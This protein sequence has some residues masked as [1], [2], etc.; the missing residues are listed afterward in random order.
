MKR[1]I[2]G[3]IMITLM[4]ATIIPL[5]AATD[6]QTTAVGKKRTFVSGFIA[7]PPRPA[8]GGMYLTFFAISMRAGE[9]GGNYNVYRL[10][11]IFVRS[12]YGFHGIALPGF[13]MGWFDGP[14]GLAG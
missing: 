11:P 14:I 5:A 9:I 8:V 1:K 13:I 7:L 10:Q 12:S 6:V 3:L 2:V 4:L